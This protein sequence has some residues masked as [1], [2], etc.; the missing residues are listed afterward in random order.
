MSHDWEGMP[1]EADHYPCRVCGSD[2]LPIPTGL[3]CVL[4]G[5]PVKVC[6]KCKAT[7]H[8]CPKVGDTVLR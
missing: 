2:Y 3:D 7:L 5:Q 6:W 4:C 1:T 8:R